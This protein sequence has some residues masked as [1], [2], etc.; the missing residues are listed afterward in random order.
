MIT[1]SSFYHPIEK[2]MIMAPTVTPTDYRG[3]DKALA[4]IVLA[5]LTFWL[6]AQSTLNIGPEMAADLGM[7]AEIMNVAI[8][9]AALFCGTFIVAAGGMAD[10]FGRVRV[11]MFGNLFNIAGSV[12]IA[13]AIGSFSTEMVIFGRVLQGVAAAC[14]M[15]SSLALVKTYW[16]G[17]ARQRAVSIWS[18]GSWGGTGF[19]A[20]VAGLIM[21]SPL[22][23]RGIFVAC[24]ITSVVSI[25]L[26]RH[27]PESAPAR[28]IGI[29][30]DWAG[31]FTLALAVISLELFITQGE[32]LGWSTWIPWGLL[33]LSVVLVVAFF[34][35]ERF[36]PW[37]VLDVTLFSNRAFTGATMVNF[38][39]SA[40]GGVVAVVMWI[41]QMAWGVSSTVSGLTS[42]G[43]AV[44]VIAFIRV[45]ERLMQS[46]GA[47]AVIIAAAILVAGAVGLMMITSVTQSTYIT[48]S[49]VGFSLFGIGL[50]LFATPI[51]DTAL[52]TLPSNR[53]GAGAG[54]FKMSSSLGAAIGIAISTSV[55]T[56]GLDATASIDSVT[57]SGTMA[58]AINLAFALFALAASIVFIPGR[59]AGASEIDANT[60]G[61]ITSPDMATTPEPI[62]SS[63]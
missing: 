4:G 25:V 28:H 60:S 20:L 23:W 62:R 11:M 44:F 19:C 10:V 54:M 36:S 33:T 15:S 61:I 3:E 18:I 26:T 45:G 47:Q 57:S 52:S 27:I 51:T 5:V 8:V 7:S 12:F 63:N 31:I 35:I 34:H 41:Q 38:I 39:M 48:I 59:N 17:R 46:R 13:A 56:A 6:F 32:A 2:R 37:P 55:F 42:I 50:G 30:L 40:T 43:F 53:A 49:L 29:R 58:L 22:G 1:P 24:A 9:A 14:I 21:T 16:I